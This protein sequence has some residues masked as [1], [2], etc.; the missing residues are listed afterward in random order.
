MYIQTQ[1]PAF[2]TA[3][4]ADRRSGRY[5]HVHTNT[6]PCLQDRT[7]GRSSVR[8][9]HTCTYKHRTDGRSP[10]REIHTYKHKS[11]PTRPHRWQIAGQGDTY[12][13]T[14]IPAFKTAQMADRRSGRYIHVHTNTNP[15]LQDR[16]DGRSPVREIHTCTYKHKSLPT[17][18]H[19]WQIAGQGDTYMYIQTPHRWQI[20]GQ[21]D[22]YIQ[23][24]IPAYKTAQ[25][26]DRWSGRYIHTN[27]N[28]CLQ[29]RT[30]G[31]SPVR[32]IHT[33]TYK[34]KSLPTRPHRWQI[35]GQGDT[36]MYIQTQIPAYKTAQMADRRSGRYIHVHT[37][38]NPCLQDRTDGRSPV[39][40]IHTCTYKHRTD[41]RSPVREIHT[42]KH[43][44]LPTRPHRWQIAGQGDTYM[45]IQ[46]QIPAYKTA[47]MAD[48]RSGRYIH[49]NTNPCL[50]DRT[51]GRLPVREIHTCTYKHKSLP[52]RPHRWQIAGQGDTYIQT[53]IPAYKTAQMADRRSG[54]Y[55]HVH[56]N[57]NPCLQDRTDGRSP[58]REIH[59][60]TYKH[61]TDG[62]SP[63]REIHTYKHK[64]LPTRPH[65]W[66][67]A[68]QGDTY[69]Y[70]QTQIPA[71]K[72]AQMADRRSGRYIHTNTNPCLQDRTDGRLPVREIHT[73]TYKHK[74]LPTRPHRWQIAGQGDTYIQTQIPAYKT[75]QM[76]DRR[77]GRYIHVHT[78][79]AQMAGCRS[80][81]YIHTN[82]NPCL[83]D[84]TDGRSPVRE[85][86]TYKHKSLPTRPHRW[87]IAGQGDTYMYIQTQIPAY[88]TAQ[89]ADRRSGRYI[90]VHT[91]TAQMADR[92]SGRYIHTNTNPCLQ[93]RTDGRSPVREIHTYKHKS[94]PTRPH[95]WQ[96][97]GQGDT[98]MYILTLHRWQIAGQGDTYIQ[99]QIPAY[100][101]AQMAGRR[102]GRYIHVHTNTNPCLQDRTDG[103]SPV[104][105][106]HT[107]TYKHRTDGRSPVREIHTNPCLQDRTDGRSPV[108][109]IH[110]YKHKSLPTRPHRWQ[111]A[112]QGD[113]YMYIQ[114]QIPAYKT[115]QMA[116]RRS[117]RY[118]HT[119]TNPCLQDRT[120]GRSPVREIHTCTY[121]HKS[122]PTRP[123]RWQIAGQG[124]T[125]MY[126]QTPHRWQIAGQGDT[127]I[128]T[129]IPAYKTAQ[130]ADRRSGRYI[131]VHT[132]TNPCLQDRTDGRSPV[133]EIHTYK[134]KSLPTRPHRWQ[135]A[136]QGDTYMYIQTQIPA[137]KTAQ[138]ADRRSGRYIHTNTN[139][140]LQDCTDGRSP[141]REI[142]TC[143]YK[144][145]TDGRLP[146][147]EI[148]T[149]KHKSLPTRPHRWQVAGQGDTYIQ[150]QIP[151][152]KTAQMAD[153]RS[154]RYIHV[155]T[156]TA[157]MADRRSG[158]YIHTNTNP[159]LQDRTDGR[160]PVREIHTYKHK[161]LP[162]R[163]HRWQIAGQG[164]TYIQ[165]QIPAY[166]T[167][168][169]ADRR[170]GRY[171]HVHT[172]T[173]Q[174]ADRRSG[175]YI[176]TNTNPCLQDRT[177]GRSPVREIHTCTYKHKSLPTRPHRW[178]IAGQ[179]DT[180]MYIQ[181]PHR[182]QI[183]GQGDT[184]IQTQIPAFKTA[185]MAGCRSGRY[186][187][188]HTNTNPCLQ[189][190]TDGRSPVRE[191]HTYKH[192]S[193]PS[194]PHRWQVAGQGDT[195]YMYIQTQIPA[196]TNPCLQDRT[197]GMSPVREIHTYKHKSLPS[198]PHRWQVAG[199]G[200]TMYMYIQ[201][202]QTPIP[203]YKTTQMA[204]RRSGRNTHIHIHTCTC[205]VHESPATRP[206]R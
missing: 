119:N 95:R 187:H 65:R 35:A 117:G 123:H 81:R 151:A 163:P 36:Y 172:N 189:D 155:H 130:M 160:S 143:T 131:H 134:H 66:Q 41:G 103:R 89:M 85:I 42:Y 194:R 192:K 156:N 64:S 48:R 142:H 59:T 186:I 191:I 193:L 125:Y 31:R 26:A 112:G 139:P 10:V 45:Y 158:R 115:A 100:K 40:E 52:T 20:A 76:A 77:S 159:C 55:I 11:L 98:Y 30:D 63:V 120:D 202:V 88:K 109:E 154:G 164:D 22:T 166:K 171:I 102:S 110:T 12:I 19:R 13:Q 101:T 51:D 157:Q 170:S 144:H 121:K 70:I 150:T 108:R 195:M 58:V 15:C 3:Q 24:Q 196:N 197:D 127:Y 97:A 179:G 44:S 17:R 8:E 1:I 79:T 38:T 75:A 94:L 96:I 145:R 54:R 201:H 181:T 111:I 28:P 105:E 148:H 60:C 72:T 132:N 61:R 169:M 152:Y 99:T 205:T 53:Q 27:T 149:Y 198:R 83:Q 146:V 129:Q 29:D 182:W 62:R 74:S 32:E 50:Q 21:G 104:R 4:M 80:G 71:Y 106:I 118:I 204:G 161:S 69:M 57:T 133:R 107:C 162:T 124:D 180:Y 86:H 178:Q 177:D 34:H 93:D 56:T 114:T 175:R 136:G 18:P 153:R 126:I 140:C 82:T 184:Y 141:V 92:R 68:G 6:N 7:D 25:M 138:M 67:I 37:N 9:I 174:M 190:R 206:H 200:D 176:H 87:Q 113:T 91:N 128:Q 5:I 49:T 203:A 2:K 23:T 116:D 122:L 168:Q 173:A 90:H 135:V 46:T 78:N 137:Y 43:K 188:V 33:C 14:Q 183:A 39:R 73:C 167:A 147:R 47:Q 165:T 84:R 199:Q 16:T 185:Q